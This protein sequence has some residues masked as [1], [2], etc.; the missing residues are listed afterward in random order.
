MLHGFYKTVLLAAALLIWC[1]FVPAASLA[2]DSGAPEPITSTIEMP[3]ASDLDSPKKPQQAKP[4]KSNRGEEVF[5]DAEALVPSSEAGVRDTPRKMDPSKEPASRLVIVKKNYGSASRQAQLIAAER[6]IEMGRYDS[7]LEIF[8]ALHEKH[9]DDPNILLGRAIALQKTGQSEAA[10]VAYEQLLKMRPDNV[11]ARVNM[12]GLMGKRYPAVA[13]TRLQDLQEQ[14]PEDV[15]VIA[16]VAVLQAGMGRYDEAL[17]FLGMAAGMEP[18]N[19]LH[20]YNMAVIA[21]RAG[22]AKEAIKYYEKALEVDTLYGGGAI[23]RGQ[24]FERIASLR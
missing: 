14:Y 3:P 18:E 15:G 1:A 21:D 11:E 2:Q 10:I 9:R 20:I 5:F 4:K 22:N 7:A 8:N 23:P 16:Q 24:V 13:L 6:A 12:L 19:P 17:R